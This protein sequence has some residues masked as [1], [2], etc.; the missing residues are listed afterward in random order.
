MSDELLTAADVEVAT[1]RGFLGEGEEMRAIT[2]IETAVR[3]MRELTVV[4]PYIDEEKWFY[5]NREMGK[6]L[7]VYDGGMPA[8]D[9]GLADKLHEASQS[10]AALA[11]SVRAKLEETP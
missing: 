3:L 7:H 2:T 11:D 4:K 5:R 6:F 10:L 9:N 1:S 8:C